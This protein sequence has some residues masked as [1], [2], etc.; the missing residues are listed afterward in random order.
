[1][2]GFSVSARHVRLTS[3]LS[4]AW[5][6]SKT[7]AP[8]APVP[9][10][11]SRSTRKQARPAAST[12][13][14]ASGAHFFTPFTP[15]SSVSRTGEGAE[16]AFALPDVT[17]LNSRTVRAK[18]RSQ[19]S[20]AELQ[21]SSISSSART[22]RAV[23][24]ADD[25][26]PAPRRSMRLSALK[27]PDTPLGRTP[28]G[29]LSDNAAARRSLR[30][31]AGALA[32]ADPDAVIQ[33]PPRVKARRQDKLREEAA[34]ESHEHV[35]REAAERK[36]AEEAALKVLREEAAERERLEREKQVRM[37]GGAMW[38]RACVCPRQL[39][40]EQELAEQKREAERIAKAEAKERKRLEKEKK[41]RAHPSEGG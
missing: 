37:R 39:I 2:R 4:S 7:V 31:T 25:E 1:M 26:R 15:A 17:P 21:R 33:T 14:A 27:E 35:V 28:L 30:G 29:E 9:A 32:A 12:V 19:Q 3:A 22:K 6:R 13:G 8:T 24:A 41:V 20:D 34:R 23:A 11:Q 5:V 38:R 16:Q 36:A 10:T 18:A 40:V